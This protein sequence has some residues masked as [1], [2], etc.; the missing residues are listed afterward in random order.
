MRLQEAHR[1]LQDYAAR[2]EQLAAAEERNRLAREMHDT[3]GHHLTVAAVQ[4]EGAQ[5]LIPSE[6]ERAARMVATVRQQV[7][8]AL[9]ELR[10]TVATLRAPL[11]ADLP[12]LMLSLTRLA[13]NFEDATGLSVHLDLPEAAPELTDFQHTAVYRMV[14]EGLTNIQR[15]AHATQVWLSF[16][17]K[18]GV[19]EVILSDDGLGFGA[20]ES[21]V[22]LRGLRSSCL[23]G[24]ELI[25]PAG[26]WSSHLA[27]A[28]GISEELVMDVKRCHR[29]PPK[30]PEADE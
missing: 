19:V 17:C 1:Q 7:A 30:V 27:P 24:R 6:P 15:H 16:T 21:Q 13:K 9:A 2:V 10:R 29:G 18:D 8:E 23:S 25:G 4:L 12:P 28:P 5:R 3:L 20:G 22:W 11:D 26:R 14:Q